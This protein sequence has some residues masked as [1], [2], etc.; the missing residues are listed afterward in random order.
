MALLLSLRD[1]KNFTRNT[2]KNDLLYYTLG[3]VFYACNRL[4][5]NHAIWHLFVIGGSACHFF[6]FAL[7][8][9]PG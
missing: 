4:P 7:G 2:K 6:A 8:V 9:I 5:F 3:A 1:L